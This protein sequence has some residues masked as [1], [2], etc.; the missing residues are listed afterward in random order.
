M[1]ESE[2]MVV[3]STVPE[4]AESTRLPISAHPLCGW[5]LV[6]VAF[7]GAIG[8]GL[9]GAAY[10]VNMMIYKSRLPLAVK[11]ALNLLTGS[12]AFMLWALIASAIHSNHR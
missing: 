10:G 8:G 12:V 6:L 5:P 4:K 1:Q 7:G 9:G 2:D 3:A 11:V